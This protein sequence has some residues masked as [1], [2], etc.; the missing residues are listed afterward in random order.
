[1]S[2]ARSLATVSGLTVVSRTAGFVRDTL[3]AMFLGAGFE[4]DAFFVAQRIPNLFRSLFAEGAFTAAFVPIYAS[5][6]EKKSYEAAQRFAGEALAL[7]IAAL[8]PFSMLVIWL[9]PFVIMVIAPGFQDE[10]E[11]YGMAVTFTRITFPYLLLISITALQS[12]VLNARGRFGP[13]AA[14]PIA[15]NIVMISGLCFAKLFGWP[16]GLTLSWAVTLSGAVQAAWLFISCRRAKVTIPML[17][18]H[19]SAASKK[20]FR[21]IGPGAVGAG[22]AQINLMISTILASTLPTGAISYLFYADRLNQLPLGIVG[23]A[24]ATTL[25]PTLSRHEAKKDAKAVLH[26]TSRAIEFCFLLGLPATIGLAFVAQPIIQTLFEHGE[27]THADTVETAH[28]LMAYSLSVPAFLLVKVFAARFFARHDVKT[29]VKVAVVS[30]ITNV[31]C[32]LLFLGLFQHV[33]IALATTIATWTNAGQLYFRLRKRGEKL[34]D[35]KLKKRL[36]RLLL[37]AAG[38]AAATLLIVN[39]LESWYTGK[40]VAY[41]ITALMTIIGISFVTY[42]VLLQLTGAMRWREALAMF[43]RD[44]PASQA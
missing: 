28:A 24:V 4:A 12:G 20:L 3:T 35:D 7:L 43:R 39:V 2:F 30:M 21:Q 14:A 1:M 22:A 19:M 13:P 9:M 6:A 44:K 15:L 42:A 40:S 11:K 27:F 18:P 16:V 10:P 17:R 25:L 34:A 36:P 5:E 32:A 37:S 33:G 29:P 38:M 8:V 26:Y 23:I 41:E 31:L